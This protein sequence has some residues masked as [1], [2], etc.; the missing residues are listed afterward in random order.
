V[1]PDNDDTTL[2]R[3]L[4]NGDARAGAE[5]VYRNFGVV[6]PFLRRISPHDA[7]DL[8]Q[9]TF[10]DC[11]ESASRLR[12]AESIRAFLATVTRRHLYAYRRQGEKHRRALALAIEYTRM[13]GPPASEEESARERALLEG[14]RRL[15]PPL[16]AVLRL[17][18]WDELSNPEVALTLG[19]PVGTVASRLRRAREQL[20]DWMR[21]VDSGVQRLAVEPPSL[22]HRKQAASPWTASA[23]PNI[24]SQ[25]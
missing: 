18:Y 20:R 2:L 13:L 23:R 3:R 24:A 1:T 16:R 8:A 19:V 9:Q 25:E 22:L 6:A 7:D 14:V 15:P 17:S 5:L 21:S 12:Q 4:R 10:L 11:L